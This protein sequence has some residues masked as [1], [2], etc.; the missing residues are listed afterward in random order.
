MPAPV[1]LPA[2]LMACANGDTACATSGSWGSRASSS[3]V[4]TQGQQRIKGGGR[5][6]EGMTDRGKDESQISWARAD[7][8]TTIVTTSTIVFCAAATESA[9]QTRPASAMWDGRG[10][11]A[12]ETTNLHSSYSHAHLHDVAV[13]YPALSRW[14]FWSWDLQAGMD[15][16]FSASPAFDYLHC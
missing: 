5:E 15:F 7:A 14:M 16:S 12:G 4:R 3:N 1:L 9:M 8:C 2:Q 6:D 13:Q 11:T 10:R